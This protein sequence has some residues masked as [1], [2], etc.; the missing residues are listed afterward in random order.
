MISGTITGK[1]WLP[2]WSLYIVEN[3][4]EYWVLESEVAEVANILLASFL[5]ISMFERMLC[6]F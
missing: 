2:L 5:L 1:I 4:S 6:T 3:R